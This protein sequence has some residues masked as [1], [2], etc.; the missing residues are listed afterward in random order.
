[1]SGKRKRARTDTLIYIDLEAQDDGS[2]SDEQLS[3][4]GTHTAHMP[5]WRPVPHTSTDG[6]LVDDF[7]SEND[8]ETTPGPWIRPDDEADK[9]IELAGQ[10]R[11]KLTSREEDHHAWKGETPYEY[12]M[13]TDDRHT[14]GMFLLPTKVRIDVVGSELI[15]ND[16]QV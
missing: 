11:D 7:Q 13:R 10:Y 4:D 8:Q 9:L 16:V 15:S 14:C 5:R 12:P 2:D 1:M 3:D 6:F